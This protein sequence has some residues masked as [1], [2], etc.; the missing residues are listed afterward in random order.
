MSPDVFLVQ[1]T[2]EESTHDSEA[3][4]WA[5]EPIEYNFYR[6]KGWHKGKKDKDFG[7]VSEGDI[8]LLYCTGN[9]EGCPKQIK[10]IFEV[11]EI[12]EE[13]EEEIGTPTNRLLDGTRL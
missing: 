6:H 8:V 7:K 12:V 2:G 13:R 11:E 10:Y 3:E 4:T 1:A 9:V 5:E